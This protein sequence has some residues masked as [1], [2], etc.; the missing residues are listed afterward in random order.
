[1]HKEMCDS[2]R[3]LLSAKNNDY[4]NPEANPDPLAPFKNFMMCEHMDVAPAEVGM[5]IRM[6]DKFSRLSSFVKGGFSP[7]VADEKLEDTIMDII[8]YGILL[9]AYKQATSV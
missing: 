4:A 1:M 3:K 7:Q 9:L 8:N 5:L 2:A 6:T